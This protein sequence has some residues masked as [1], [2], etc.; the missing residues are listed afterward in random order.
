MR[1]I[2]EHPFHLPDIPGRQ[3]PVVRSE[4]TKVDDRIAFHTSGKIDVRVHV[5]QR[6]RTRRA[7]H[8]LTSVKPWIARPCDRSPAAISPVHEQHMVQLVN[9]FETQH[10]RRVT[11]LLEDGR[12]RQCR[13]E[14]VGRVMTYDSTKA[15]ERRAA[16]RRFGV[17]RQGVEKALDELRSLQSTND[18]PFGRGEAWRDLQGSPIF[19]SLYC[20]FA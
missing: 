9:R 19:P 16:G 5:T 7:E 15:A 6:E 8:G 12:S 14:T 2:E 17:V 1:R 3:T 4:D 13:L 20:S 10:E 11:V 18:A